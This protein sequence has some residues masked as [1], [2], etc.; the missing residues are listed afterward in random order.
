[1]YCIIVLYWYVYIAGQFG[2]PLFNATIFAGFLSTVVSSIF[3]TL[4]DY[5]AA[6]SLSRVPPPPKSAV[7][8]GILL[9]GIGSVISGALGAG[10]A[11]TSST[12]NL[13]LIGITRVCVRFTTL[14]VVGLKLFL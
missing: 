6:A 7:N 2:T 5:H 4:G 11:T 3:E 9:E 13:S 12:G 1:M 14:V 8:R 10:H